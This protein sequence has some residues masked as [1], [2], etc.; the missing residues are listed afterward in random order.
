MNLAMFPTVN[1]ISTLMATAEKSNLN[2]DVAQYPSLPGK[3]GINTDVDAHL[4]AIPVN[5]KHKDAA[6]K[7][8]EIITSDEVQMEMTRKTA[9]LSP[10]KDN[11][12][13]EGFAKDAQ[14][15]NGKNIAGIF[16]SKRIEAPIRSKY[17][18]SPFVEKEI[19]AYVSGQKDLN[20]AIRDAEEAINKNIAGLKGK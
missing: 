1:I 18:T 16:K 4:F 17:S 19:E 14:G 12:F 20:T 8:L 11:K 3:P 5:A 15:T 13:V 9:R 10:L 6:M 2:W 7:V